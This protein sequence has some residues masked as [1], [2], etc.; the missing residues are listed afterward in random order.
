[1]IVKNYAIEAGVRDL[2]G[3]AKQFSQKYSR[4]VLENP[5]LREVLHTPETVQR[6]LGPVKQIKRPFTVCP[7]VVRFGYMF[8]GEPMISLLQVSVE[9]GGSGKFEVFGVLPPIQRQYARIALKAV[10]KT[11]SYD[12]STVDITVFFPKPLISERPE[13]IVGL[14]VYLG[15]ISGL[16]N[17]EINLADTIIYGCGIDLFGNIFLDCS[18]PISPF[19][20][21]MEEENIRVMYGATGLNTRVDFSKFE[22][23]PLLLES[24]N[25]EALVRMVLANNQKRTT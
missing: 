7:G 22:N 23:S 4:D 3:I 9:R 24:S 5:Q 20:S 16:I 1:M 19:I 11:T 10:Q 14:P 8:Q 13:N 17:T 25:G 12:I 2:Y 6:I 15:I 18:E 21:A